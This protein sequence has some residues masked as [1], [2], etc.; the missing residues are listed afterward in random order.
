MRYFTI[1]M[2][3]KFGRNLIE[4]FGSGMFRNLQSSYLNQ[5]IIWNL[6]WG[7]GIHSKMAWSSGCWQEASVLHW[8]LSGSQ[9]SLP[10]KP[11]HQVPCFLTKWQLTSSEWSKWEQ[12]IITMSFFNLISEVTYYHLCHILPV[13]ETN[14]DTLQEKSTLRHE[15]QETRIT[16]T[17]LEAGYHEPR[18]PLTGE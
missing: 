6:D 8:L 14:P 12:G 4:H 17:I 9:S 13:P 16:G 7:W 1:S 10:H 11:I 18:F 2:R 3:Q 15:Y 5:L